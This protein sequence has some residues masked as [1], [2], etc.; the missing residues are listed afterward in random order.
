MLEHPNAKERA[1]ERAAKS[2]AA[3]A[4]RTCTQADL[5]AEID[6]KIVQKLPTFD[7]TVRACRGD[8]VIAVVSGYRAR[9]WRVAVERAG[10]ATI[11][12]FS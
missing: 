1:Q 4:E 5:V 10:D 2:E 8:V 9:G 3:R 6:A 7:V 12:K 11:L